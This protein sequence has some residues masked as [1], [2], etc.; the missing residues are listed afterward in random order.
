[1]RRLMRIVGMAEYGW[2]EL[3]LAVAAAAAAGYLIWI[4]LDWRVSF[5]ALI[6]LA[7]VVWFF[8]DPNRSG[9]SDARVLLSP[10]DGTVTD[11]IEIEELEFIAGKALRIGIFL[12][13]L[14]V[15]VNRTC[16]E[17]TVIFV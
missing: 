7:I 5:I 6:P 4:F 16:S 12:S 17:G 10:A 1:M 3:L 2:D 9:P 15:H 14:N 13:P 11:V 8:R